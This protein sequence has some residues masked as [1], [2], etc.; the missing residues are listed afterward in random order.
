MHNKRWQVCLTLACSRSFAYRFQHAH[1]LH[2]KYRCFPCASFAFENA[3]ENVKIYSAPKVIKNECR[4]KSIFGSNFFLWKITTANII[5]FMNAEISDRLLIGSGAIS[6]AQLNHQISCNFLLLVV[7]CEAD[8]SH[9]LL[10][11]L[12]GNEQSFVNISS[13]VK[14]L[15]ISRVTRCFTAMLQLMLWL[16]QSAFIH[17]LCP[18]PLR[19][20]NKLSCEWCELHVNVTDQKCISVEL[21]ELRVV[22]IARLRNTKIILDNKARTINHW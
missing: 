7:R 9:F 14:R 15:M 5:N 11:K 13:T 6:R 19:Q 17:Y 18:P 4:L 22:F 16:K 10:L 1:I 12:K 2:F 3:A 20:I 21:V 8:G